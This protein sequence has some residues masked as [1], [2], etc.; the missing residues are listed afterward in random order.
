[1]RS[2]KSIAKRISNLLSQ[3]YCFETK[4]AT[5]KLTNLNTW[6]K[7]K[8]DKRFQYTFVMIIQC[9]FCWCCFFTFVLKI[10]QKKF[11]RMNSNGKKY[12]W[13]FFWFELLLE[14]KQ[15]KRKNWKKI[16][17]SRYR[18]MLIGNHIWIFISLFFFYITL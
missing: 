5:K 1:M 8:K 4:S 10:I 11:L 9:C 18:T 16:G 6:F 2:F 3:V 7:H 17:S 14:C 15:N 12:F 13:I